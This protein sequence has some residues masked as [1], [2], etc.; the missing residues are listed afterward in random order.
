MLVW[1]LAPGLLTPLAYAAPLVIVFD[2]LFMLHL[3]VMRRVPVWTRT[4]TL[5]LLPRNVAAAVNERI[6]GRSARWWH[7]AACMVELAALAVPIPALYYTS[8]LDTSHAMALAYTQLAAVCVASAYAP[9]Y[10]SYAEVTGE[11]EWHAFRE[12]RAWLLLHAY[13]NF[14]PVYMKHAPGELAERDE[15]RR[16]MRYAGRS[17]VATQR[18]MD[19]VDRHALTASRVEPERFFTMERACYVAALEQCMPRLEYGEPGSPRPDR[20]AAAVTPPLARPPRIFAVHPHGLTAVTLACLGLMHGPDPAL[21]DTRNL[22]TCVA[23]I[24]FRIPI[25]R[26]W[27]LLCGCIEAS[28]AAMAAAL[29]R[30]RDLLVA[31]GG[32]LEQAMTHY[33]RVDIVWTRFGFCNMALEYR[34]SIVPIYAFG[35]NDTYWSYNVLPEWRL[36]NY[37]RFGYAFPYVF[38]GPFPSTVSPA[39]GLPID[40]AR[41]YST[42]ASRQH[43]EKYERRHNADVSPRSLRSSAERDRGGD[44]ED[45]H[46]G[47]SDGDTPLVDLGEVASRICSGGI[48]D[49]EREMGDYFGAGYGDVQRGHV[50]PSPGGWFVFRLNVTRKTLRDA[51]NTIQGR[52]AANAGLLQRYDDCGTDDD[53]D[54]FVTLMSSQLDDKGLLRAADVVRIQR[55]FYAQLID[56]RDCLS[57]VVADRIPG[58]HSETWGIS[59]PQLRSLLKRDTRARA[60]LDEHVFSFH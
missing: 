47:K 37:A 14:T 56:M 54:E 29:A 24:L 51:R 12:S 30:H 36:S 50:S 13:F 46:S 20:R 40:T 6:H 33:G 15:M 52:S 10:H 8:V 34:A 38:I 21:P 1:L 53:D 22:R 25:I 23:N 55:A 58:A 39:I 5:E 18:A 42:D 44:D 4:A 31:P 41:I 48:I 26:E 2:A 19:L 27:V 17:A 7:V 59:L 45:A 11:W 60:E 9:W 16:Q 32:M 57:L 3:Y 49:P 35:E 43:A 28:P